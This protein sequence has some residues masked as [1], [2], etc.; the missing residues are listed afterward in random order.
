MGFQRE[1]KK[2]DLGQRKGF[3]ISKS[4]VWMCDV[5]SVH[6]NEAVANHQ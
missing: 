5:T 6:C 1:K 2:Q 4:F 3:C